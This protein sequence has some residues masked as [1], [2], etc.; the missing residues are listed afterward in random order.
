MCLVF[1]CTVCSMC[2]VFLACLMTHVETV[3][4]FRPTLR[5]SSKLS[6][7]TFHEK[8]SA[9]RLFMR[10]DSRSFAS[11]IHSPGQC[12]VVH[13]TFCVLLSG[14]VLPLRL[15]VP[16]ISPIGNTDACQP[17]PHFAPAAGLH[18]VHQ[19]GQEPSCVLRKCD[20][21]HSL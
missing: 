5:I 7:V 8:S 21:R 14:A 20:R 18:L 10:A 13:G 6:N 17:L 19:V 1:M 4:S 3:R 12:L 16:P 15:S 2:S 11:C 9:S